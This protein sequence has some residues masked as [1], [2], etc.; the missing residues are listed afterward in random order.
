[1]TEPYWRIFSPLQIRSGNK[2]MKS[3]LAPAYSLSYLRYLEPLVDECSEVFM[4]A[5]EDLACQPIDLGEW[6]QWYDLGNKR[7]FLTQSYS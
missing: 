1:M 6:L 4:K 5:M 7:F 3:V 2:Q